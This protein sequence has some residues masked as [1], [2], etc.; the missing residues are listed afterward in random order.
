MKIRDSRSSAVAIV[1]T[2]HGEEMSLLY[3]HRQLRNKMHA[4]A[5]ASVRDDDMIDHH[6]LAEQSAAGT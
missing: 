1:H 6:A 5:A 2:D 4:A 3:L